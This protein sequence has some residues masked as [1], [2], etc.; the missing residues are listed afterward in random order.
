MHNQH[1]HLLD[2]FRGHIIHSQTKEVLE[3]GA[4]NEHRNAA[5]KTHRDRIGN[6]LNHCPQA[7]DAHDQQ[8]AAGQNGADHEVVETV[9]GADA[10]KDHNERAGG[11][12]DGDFCL[13]QRR[14]E[15][16]RDDR[17]ENAGFRFYA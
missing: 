10:I 12:A 16:T 2:E 13:A 9:F 7:R 6:I 14:D 3:L 11:S 15:E 8:K 5:G 4:K 1:F 17:R